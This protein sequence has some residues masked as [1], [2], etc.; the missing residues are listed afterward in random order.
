MSATKGS[1]ANLTIEGAKY[2]ITCNQTT[3]IGLPLSEKKKVFIQVGSEKKALKS[4]SKS[5]GL[6]V[7]VSAVKDAVITME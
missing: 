5:N 2:K 3:E 6:F 7:V 4:V 1:S